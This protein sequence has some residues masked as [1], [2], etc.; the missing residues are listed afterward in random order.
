[1]AH[2][3]QFPFFDYDVARYAEF[4]YPK[5]VVGC[6][7]LGIFVG[8]L[9]SH[10][11]TSFWLISILAAALCAV[12]WWALLWM[13]E[14]RPLEQ[15]HLGIVQAMP[16]NASAAAQLAAFER[17]GET[18]CLRHLRYV[19]RA[20]QAQVE[21]EGRNTYAVESTVLGRDFLVRYP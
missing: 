11:N 1:M 20:H 17:S 18:L 9:E 3:K 12:F 13:G 7:I 14:R 5:L 16:W 8:M 15:R 2:E 21:R 10:G 6:S 19:S 4:G